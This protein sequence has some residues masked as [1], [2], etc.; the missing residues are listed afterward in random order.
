MAVKV[1]QKEI[2]VG[3]KEK[4]LVLLSVGKMPIGG[5]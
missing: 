4:E 2:S 5:A 1:S 3:K